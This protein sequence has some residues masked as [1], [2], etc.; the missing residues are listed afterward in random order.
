MGLLWT[1][2]QP[3]PETST[4]QHTTLKGEIIYSP[5]GFDHTTPGSE[6]PQTHALDSAA[7]GIG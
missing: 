5:A 7:I 6:R 2:D 1:S 4:S 3:D